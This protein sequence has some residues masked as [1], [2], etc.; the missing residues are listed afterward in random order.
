MNPCIRKLVLTG[1]LVPSLMFSS[2]AL[3]CSDTPLI[4]TMCAFAGNFAPRGYALAQGQ[5]L[6]ISQNTA[7]FSILGTTYG[8]DGRTTF[9]LP[10]TRGRALIGAGTGPGLSSYSLGARGGVESVV[11]TQD[12]MPSHTHTASTQMSGDIDVDGVISLHAFSGNASEKSPTGNV[13]AKG[14]SK[15]MYSADV[16]DVDM[17]PDSI[18]FSLVASNNLSASTTVDSAG[19]DQSH[20]NRMPYVVVNWIIALQGIFPTRN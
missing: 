11:L 20:E 16:P 14:K 8:G 6:S 5:L 9:G 4:G 13:L 12:Q 2:N 3:A 19:G 18:S 17:S 15:S 10:D 1:A 7:L